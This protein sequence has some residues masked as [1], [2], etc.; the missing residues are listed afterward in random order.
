MNATSELLPIHLTFALKTIFVCA[1]NFKPEIKTKHVLHAIGSLCIV[2][3]CFGHHRRQL[4]SSKLATA[5]SDYRKTL[6]LAFLNQL[7][8]CRKQ[9]W[10]L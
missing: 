7:C 4:A 5:Q 10:L 3:R 9:F 1:D 2:C 8:G 6:G